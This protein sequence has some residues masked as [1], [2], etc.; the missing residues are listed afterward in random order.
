ME[1]PRAFDLPRLADGYRANRARAC[2]FIE[3]GA[4]ESRE[5]FRALFGAANPYRASVVLIV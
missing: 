4:A 1:K 3:F 2:Q 5:M